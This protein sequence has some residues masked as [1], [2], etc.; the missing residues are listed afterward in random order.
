MRGF[1]L[2]A[3]INDHLWFFP[4]FFD[5]WGMR[6]SLLTTT[7][8]GFFLISGLVLGIVRGAK[9]ID[10]PFWEVTKLVLK[11]AWT[12]YATYV[13]LVIFFTVLAWTV[14]SGNPNIKNGIMVDHNWLQMIWQTLTFQYT[15]GWADYLKFYAIYIAITPLAMWLLRRGWWYVV[16]GIS[17]A[18]WILLPI[19]FENETWERVQYLQPIAWQVIFFTGLIIGFHWPQISDWWG[20]QKAKNR[21]IATNTLIIIGLVTF[22]ANVF[23]VF[24]NNLLHL[25]WTETLQT[26]ADYLR[27]HQFHKESMSIYRYLLFMI[28]FWTAFALINRYLDKIVKYCDWLLGPFGVNS[29]YVYTLQ[30][31]LMFFAHLYFKPTNIFLNCLVFVSF[32]ALIYVAIRTRF[33]M[34][35]IPR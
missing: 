12:L 3:I 6:G 25:P 11:R 31:F 32:V 34:K 14:F 15:Y 24:G 22:L 4:N 29:L 23:A 20:R 26:T 35:I 16:A 21:R 7:A 28:W 10:A 18:V 8:E 2:I 33:L 13:V 30:A 27:T 19:D 1:F 17:I 9:L 5:W